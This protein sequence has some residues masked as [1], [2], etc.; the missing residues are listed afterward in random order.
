M[1]IQTHL[2]GR[3]CEETQ[4]KDICK[5][6]REAR[7]RLSLPALRKKQTMPTPGS[8]A[9]NFQKQDNKFLLSHLVGDT[10][11]WQPQKTIAVG[12]G[13]GDGMLRED[14]SVEVMFKLRHHQ[15]Q[16]QSALVWGRALQIRGQQRHGPCGGG[17]GLST[18][19]N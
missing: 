5:P 16:S 7:S 8:W 10:L 11:L 12:V 6:R 13:Y 2:E 14:L 3:Q 1:G 9:S 19:K 17:G 15:R 18:F 4:G